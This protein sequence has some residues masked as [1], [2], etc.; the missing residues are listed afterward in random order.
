[1][2]AKLKLFKKTVKM[3][4]GSLML[5]FG[6]PKSDSNQIKRAV[7]DIGKL[8]ELLY[9]FEKELAFIRADGRKVYEVYVNGQKQYLL[10]PDTMQYLHQRT[11]SNWTIKNALDYDLIKEVK[12]EVEEPKETEISMSDI[13][14]FLKGMYPIPSSTEILLGLVEKGK[15]TMEKA[16]EW[17]DR[18]AKEGDKY[19]E[20]TGWKVCKN[21]KSFRKNNITIMPVIDGVCNNNGSFIINSVSETCNHFDFKSDGVCK[22]CMYFIV[23]MVKRSNVPDGWCYKKSQEDIINDSK[24]HGCMHFKQGQSVYCK[25]CDKYIF[26]P[27]VKDNLLPFDLKIVKQDGRIETV[28]SDCSSLFSDGFLD[29]IKKLPFYPKEIRIIGTDEVRDNAVIKFEVDIPNQF[30]NPETY[31]CKR[32]QF[33][34][35]KIF[36]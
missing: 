29:Q 24:N 26:A 35:S 1:M 18:I 16:L 15:M 17:M 6:F 13:S 20:G 11:P 27:C 7:D 3:L 31:P 28:P 12:R 10:E 14:D 34:C 30:I 19:T 21:C 2:E 33:F 25:D 22:D 23:N 9:D 32:H 5:M 4:F 36:K 8:H